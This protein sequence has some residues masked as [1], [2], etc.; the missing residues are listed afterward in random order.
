MAFLLPCF[1]IFICY[2]RIFYI[3]RVTSLKAQEPQLKANGSVRK[4]QSNNVSNF[5][6]DKR[7]L[8]NISLPQTNEVPK[9]INQPTDGSTRRKFLS[10]NKD[11]EL[12]FIDTS[13]ES[14]LPPTLSQLQRKNVQISVDHEVAPSPSSE[15][16]AF[17]QT[18]STTI[19][20]FREEQLRLIS[21]QINDLSNV[22]NNNHVKSSHGS[23]KL[24]DDSIAED[25]A[26]ISLVQVIV[27]KI[28]LIPVL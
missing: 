14:D 3:V 5:V 8:N 1:A 16:N 18:T 24:S 7:K 12:K 21:R 15:L 11:E 22:A 23:R 26:T 28:L 20:S 6:A 4:V 17:Q 25:S 10:K 9:E 19:N 2:A 13:V 27:L